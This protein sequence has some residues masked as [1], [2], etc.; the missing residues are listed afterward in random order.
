MYTLSLIEDE[1]NNNPIIYD[2][3]TTK[4]FMEFYEEYLKDF[5]KYDI[6]EKANVSFSIRYMKKLMDLVTIFNTGWKQSSVEF[7]RMNDILDKVKSGTYVDPVTN[8]RKWAN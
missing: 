8:L 1:I 2:E 3:Q 6:F 4:F 7:K 5:I